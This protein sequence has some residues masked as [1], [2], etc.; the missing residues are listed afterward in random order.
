MRFALPFEGAL[1]PVAAA[2]RALR[3]TTQQKLSPEPGCTLRAKPVVLGSPE[4]IG[5]KTTLTLAKKRVLC[6]AAFSFG[7]DYRSDGI[8]QHP[9]FRSSS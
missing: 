3:Q 6:F 4:G 5:V 2:S 1:S 8:A 9:P 7:V